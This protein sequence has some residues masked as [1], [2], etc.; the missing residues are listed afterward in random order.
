M[1]DRSADVR[2][3]THAASA[4]RLQMNEHVSAAAAVAAEFA[5]RQNARPSTEFLLSGTVYVST[6]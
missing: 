2:V 1:L 4:R 6:V 5:C 3:R